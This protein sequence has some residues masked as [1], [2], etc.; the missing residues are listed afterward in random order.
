MVLANSGPFD[1]EID[2]QAL[3]KMSR[4]KRRVRHFLDE[5]LL[6]S[7]KVIYVAGEGRL[8]NLASA[9]GHPSEVMSMSFCGQA[10][11]CEFLAKNRGK[12]P[13]ALLSLPP[14][15][16]RMIA[17]LQL[18]AMGIRIDALT[19]EQEKYL[20]SWREGT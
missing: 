2:L 1:N 7:G 9:E 14:E 16:D 10:L 17:S 19:A 8:V 5:Y 4:R 13:K 3:E 12:L 15:V 6:A 18:E 11:A 20:A